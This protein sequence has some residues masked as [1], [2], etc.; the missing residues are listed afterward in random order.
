LYDGDGEGV[1]VFAVEEDLVAVWEAVIMK[2]V[3]EWRDELCG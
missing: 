1:M 2:L 3:E